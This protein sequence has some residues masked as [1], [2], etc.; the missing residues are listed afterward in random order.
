MLKAKVAKKKRKDLTAST[1][2]MPMGASARNP[3]FQKPTLAQQV[4]MREIMTARQMEMSAGLSATQPELGGMVAK[5]P[6]A[7]RPKVPGDADIYD[8]RIGGYGKSMGPKESGEQ[9]VRRIMKVKKK[10]KT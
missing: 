2:S 5:G 4:Q 1:A 8:E 9:A 3:E 7:S 6:S 10:K